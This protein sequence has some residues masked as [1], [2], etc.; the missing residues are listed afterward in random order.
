MTFS[1]KQIIAEMTDDEFERFLK[2]WTICQM[3]W[4]CIERENARGR[5]PKWITPLQRLTYDRAVEVRDYYYNRAIGRLR[6]RRHKA[7]EHATR[8]R[9]QA[10]A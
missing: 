8:C 6:Y 10:C 4:R 7:N 2:A 1:R 5:M 3:F 9:D